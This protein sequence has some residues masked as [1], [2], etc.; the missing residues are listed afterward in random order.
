MNKPSV[1]RKSALAICVF[2]LGWFILTFFYTGIDYGNVIG[3]ILFSALVY[4]AVKMPQ[5]NS[6]V[7]RFWHTKAGKAILSAAA[8]AA[9]CAFA[10]V[11]I[12]TAKMTIAA[13]ENPVSDG[14]VIV[15]GCKVNG[16]RPSLSLKR[17][18][19]KAAE[20]LGENKDAVC[21]VTGGKGGSGKISEAQCM[22]NYLISAGI[23]KA[24]IIKEDRA[25]N[26][27]QNMAYSKEII[28]SRSLD[29]RAV[30]IT[31]GFHEYRACLIAEKLG[32]EA[33]PC[34]ARS[35][36]IVLPAQYIRELLSILNQ[37]LFA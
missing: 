6:Y 15:L 16:T 2:M 35:V 4:Y 11:V 17:R 27:R 31:N 19:E 26:T 9:A 12:I 28:E 21:I 37:L 23:D 8:A 18:L 20:Y 25:I 29:P 10:F 22:E 3:T 30:I 7:I 14:T 1:L 33:Y 32:I 36:Y 34:S 24:R 5:I 13:F